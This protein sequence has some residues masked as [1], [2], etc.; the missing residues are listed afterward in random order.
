[1]TTP[2]SDRNLDGYGAPLIPWEKVRERLDAGVPQAPGTGGPNRHTCWLATVRPDG[3]PHV[4]PLGLLW[5]D[6]A[7]WFNAGPGT[8]KARNPAADPHC[9]VTVALDP[10]DIVVEGTAQKVTDDATLRR[11]VDAYAADDGWEATIEDGA[12]TAPFSAPSAGPPPWEVYR[13]TPSTVF[14]LGAE[15][16]LGATRFTF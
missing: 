10:F 6:G 9:V 4:M 2:V 3:R 14:A 15:D 13:V 12:L 11:V 5:L 7:F 16:P 1:M 8:R